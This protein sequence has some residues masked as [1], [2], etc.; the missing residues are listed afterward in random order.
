M[1]IAIK[2]AGRSCCS[3]HNEHDSK[4]LCIN[5]QT[6]LSRFHA[7][8]LERNAAAGRMEF[9]RLRQIRIIDY[10][11]TDRRRREAAESLCLRGRHGLLNHRCWRARVEARSYRL[12]REQSRAASG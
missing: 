4:G 11:S 8:F 12:H 7:K 5:I 3:E 9:F 6:P 1:E 2:P 10:C